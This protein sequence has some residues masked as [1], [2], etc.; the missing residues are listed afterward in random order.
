MSSVTGGGV[1]EAF[2]T[3]PQELASS[4]PSAASPA[5]AAPEPGTAEAPTFSEIDSQVATSL[6]RFFDDD[7]LWAQ[8]AHEVASTKL[9][10]SIPRGGRGEAGAAVA[11]SGPTSFRVRVPKPYPGVQ[12]RKSKRLDD[13]YPRYAK[14]G[15]TVTGRIEDDEWLRIS[16][17]VF[18]PMRVAGAPILE[19][20]PPAAAVGGAAEPAPSS[21]PGGRRE[22]A[23][24]GMSYWWTCGPGNLNAAALSATD[25]KVGEAER[26]P[27]C[28]LGRLHLEERPCKDPERLS[29]LAN[30]AW[31]ATRQREDF[32]TDD[33]GLPTSSVVQET[34]VGLTAT[35]ALWPESNF[36]RINPFSDTPR[37]GSPAG[38]PLKSRPVS[39]A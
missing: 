7:S 25:L 19:P 39:S 24:G 27:D 22:S 26:G 1:A 29:S 9:S 23:G 36:D 12:Y 11:G 33:D 8:V 5:L 15:M 2:D 28:K 37:G 31:R 32:F 38:T 10:L 14:E 18:L 35:Q 30:N 16:D 17:R 3:S 21:G 34:S 6:D 4:E 20:L 13:R